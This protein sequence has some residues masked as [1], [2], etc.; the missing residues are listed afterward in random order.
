[1]WYGLPYARF[2]L[3]AS[4]P[5]PC[6][7]IDGDG[8]GVYMY[9]DEKVRCKNEKDWPN[10]IVRPPVYVKNERRKAVE[11]TRAKIRGYVTSSESHTT[12]TFL[13]L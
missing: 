11:A 8:I 7:A 10:D 13:A 12:S 6:F 4:L 5:V 1:V 2:T 3:C 9:Q